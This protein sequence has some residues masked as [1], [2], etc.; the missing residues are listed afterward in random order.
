M[1]SGAAGTAPDG[2]PVEL[3]ALLEPRGE[4]ELVAAVAAP[5]ARVLEVGCGAGRVTRELV[6]LGF[7]V[8]A[9]DVCEAM[10]DRLGELP[11]V[12]PLCGAIERMNPL[13]QCDIVLCGSNLVNVGREQRVA[14]LEACRRWVTA[15]GAV[16]IERLDPRWADPAWAA[17]KAARPGRVEPVS[18]ITH[19]L[20]VEPPLVTMRVEYVAADGRRWE[21]GPF[22]MEVVDD[23]ALL[24]SCAR[25]G[26]GL[27]RWLP[28]R[29]SDRSWCVVRA[30]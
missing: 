19:D 11:G 3:Y 6:R 21:Q 30:I 29:G 13:H 26:L 5:G 7:R 4:A 25:A 22:T 1:P 14:L 17:E 2:S 8:V 23:D 9:V 15:S 24:E 27:E 28:W 20:R 18:C 16:L 12:E 10:L